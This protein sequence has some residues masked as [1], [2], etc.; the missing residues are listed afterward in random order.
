MN[1]IKIKSVKKIANTSKRYDIQ[2][3]N[4]NFFANNILIHN[5]IIKVWYD[6]DQ[7]HISTNGV[8]N[9][10]K[11]DLQSDVGEFKTFG[12][13]FASVFPN[14]LY[15]KLNKNYTY[16]FELVSPWNRVVVPYKKTDIYHTGTRDNESGEEI[17]I[18]VGIKKPQEFSFASLEDTIKMSEELPF[19]EEGYVVVD[20]NWNRVK[21]K[22]PAYLAVHRLCNNGVVTRKRILELIRMNEQSEFLSYYPEYQKEFDLVK[23]EYI[24][25]R[26]KIYDDFVWYSNIKESFDSRKDFAMEAKKRTAPAFLFGL[27][28]GKFKNFDEFIDTISSEKLEKIIEVKK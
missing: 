16:M 12:T 6:E 17:N 5:S 3:K 27:L 22:S 28:D 14:K 20:K 15:G 19:D 23:D 11:A 2:T 1:K 21:I 26:D 9:A 13:L 18:D 7:W 24:T 8:I 25:Y 10:Y 4:N